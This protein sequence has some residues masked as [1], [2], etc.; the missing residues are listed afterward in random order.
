[1]SDREHWDARYASYGPASAGEVG[2]PPAFLPNEASFP[3][4]G[5]A[6]EVACGRGRGAVWLATRGMRVTALDVSPIA[7]NFAR[8]LAA[9]AG[10][11]DSCRFETADLDHGL[12]SGPRVDLVLCHM[13]RNPLL[14]VA[15]VGRLKPGGLI[16]IAQLSEVDVGPGP[17]RGP[18]GDLRRRFGHLELVAFD[19]GDGQAALL[20]RSP[21]A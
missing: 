9:E 1:M 7:I 2:P 14:D 15:L 21:S 19:E 12:P 8:T 3:T 13:F 17:H 20:A 10:V 18:V 16:A 11:G 5:T 4:A 6:I